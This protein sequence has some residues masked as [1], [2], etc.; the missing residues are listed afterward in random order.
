[1]IPIDASNRFAVCLDRVLEHEGGY[2]DHPSDPGGRTMQGVTQAT[3]DDWRHKH[4]LPARHVR[5][6]QRHELEA[7][8]RSGYWARVRADELPIG[9]DYAVFDAAVNFGPAR[10]IRWLQQAVGVPADGIICP[11]TMGAVKAKPALGTIEGMC[12]RR[13]QFLRGLSTWPVFGAGW[14]R[15]VNEVEAAALTDAEAVAMPP[16]PIPKP[17]AAARAARLLGAAVGVGE[18]AIRVG[19]TLLA[20]RANLA[21]ARSRP[22]LS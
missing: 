22:A 15:R 12:A 21:C 20:A 2:A 9:I 4:S 8:Y 6:I 7:I 17:K 5:L 18:G 13:M 14:S 1:M 10:A 16:P 19:I 3:Y 11:Q